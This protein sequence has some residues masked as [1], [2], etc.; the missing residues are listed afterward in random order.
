M[1]EGNPLVAQA[2]SQTTGV[3][4]IGIL[5]SANDLASGVKDGSWVEGGLGA[6]GVGLE[7]LSLVIDP[8][9]TLAQY[10]VSWLIE[11]VK[12]LKDCLDWLAGNPPVIQSFS[13]TWAN[14]AKE[15]QAIAGDLTNESQTGTAGW[16]GAAGEAYRGEVAEQVDA[17]AGAASL[18]DGI[19]TGVMVM[20]Q[21]VAAVRETVRDLIAALVGK[22]ITWALE[23]ACTL[24]FAT[25]LVAAQATAA[26]TSTISKVSQ[27]IRKLVKTI[28]NVGPKVRKI[29]DKLGEIIEKLSKLAK[30]LGKEGT[31]P[32]AA[33]TTPKGDVPTPK[34]HAPSTPDDVPGGA[35]VPGGHSPGSAGKDSPKTSRPDNP[36][37]TKTPPKRRY[38]KDDPVDVVSGE[39]ILS[40]VDLALPG[41]LPLVVQRTHVSSYRAGRLFGPNWASTLDQRLDLDALGVVFVGDDGVLLVYPDPPSDGSPVLPEAGARWPLTRTE[42][43]FRLAKPDEGLVTDFDAA[44]VI[45]AISDRNDNRLDFGYG[46]SGALEELRHSGGYHVSVQVT[47]GVVTELRLDD[48]VIA[49]YGHDERGRLDRV[50]NSSGKPLTFKYDLAGRLLK[51]ED[52]A[53]DWYG[54]RYDSAGRCVA[55][56]G[57]GG[58]LNGSF[59]YGESSTVFTDSLGATTTYKFT[60]ARQVVEETDPLGNTT[61]QEWDEL[62]R[63]IART[64]PLGRTT[65]F[66]YD[67]AGDLVGAT[68][69]DGTRAVAEYNAFGQPTVQVD[70]GGAVWR[71]GY[72]ERGN[73]TSSTDPAGAVTRYLR[74]GRGHLVGKTDPLGN[75]VRLEVDDAGLPIAVT[76]ALGDTHRYD[77]DQFGRVTRVTD[78]LGNVSTVSWTVEGKVLAKTY[79]DG[80]MDRWRYN[81]E[82]AQVEHVDPLGQVSRIETTHFELVAA[83]VDGNGGRTEF[84]YDTN[85]QLV[86]V[87]NPAGQVWRYLYDEAGNVVG[88]RDFTGRSVSYRYDAAG[89]LVGQTNGAGQQLRYVRDA[90][91]RVVARHSDDAVATF[92]FDEAGSLIRAVNA[93]AEVTLRRDVAGRITAE[94]VNGRTMAYSYDAAGNVIGRRTPSGMENGWRFDAAGRPAELRSGGRTVSFGYDPLGR[95]VER[96]L[97]TGAIMA[98]TW[99]GNHRLRTQT[100]STVAGRS[101]A[102]QAAVVQ[103]REYQYREDN[104]VTAVDDLL[105]GPKQFTLD[106]LG[107]VL[108]TSGERYGF[109]RGGNLSAAPGVHE[110]YDAQ[111]RV[112]VKQRRRLSRK[113]DTWH[114]SWDAEDRLIGVT[115]PDGTRWRYRYDPLGRRIAK[116]RLAADGSVAETVGFTW[117]GVTLAEQFGSDGRVVTWDSIG[118]SRPLTQIEHGQSEVDSRFYAIVTDLVGTP[119]ELLDPDGGL[120]W[121]AESTVWGAALGRLRNRADT[122]LRFPGQYHDDETGLNYNFFR[123]YD[124]ETGRYQSSDPLGLRAGPNP[125]AYAGNPLRTIDPLGLM[126]CDEAEK[127]LRD[128]DPDDPANAQARSEAWNRIYDDAENNPAAQ[129]AALQ[130]ERERLVRQ[131]GGQIRRGEG[132]VPNDLAGGRLDAPQ[133]HVPGSQYHVQGPGQGTPGLNMDGTFHDGDPRWPRGTYQWLYERGFAWPVEGP[134]AGRGPGGGRW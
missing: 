26:I 73:L 75:T 57:A 86:A 121:R 106:P 9:G 10:G 56:E 113:P 123:Y 40:Q 125:Y 115:T 97:D 21:V 23:E 59:E 22:L 120:A 111:G 87:K 100:I 8:I 35:D 54:Y 44:G 42:T 49:R 38:C 47:G 78:A 64:D 20:G 122:P 94:T 7:A 79:P 131:A 96:L 102:R 109:D 132:G 25:P 18:C 117:D 112:V 124:P 16:V 13:D 83:S 66:E 77:R 53:G 99:D 55:N 45:R 85:M 32:S 52:R 30:R 129:A 37:D 92:E 105:A 4:G 43:G 107:R 62:D 19:S 24:G 27:V 110:Q 108:E 36:Q 58:F 61:Y 101:P 103:Q 2:Q 1:P 76:N 31:S 14:V 68:Q 128:L 81:G 28:S 93:D 80:T 39:V 82:G 50:V 84:E 69:P 60:E 126:T 133:A 88:E 74:D 127:A 17:V 5:E 6:V 48:V 71:L 91:G 12:P 134:M 90:M 15:V 70:P 46:P 29:V 116:E 72:D 41:S 3:T 63:L 130:A 95:E 67:E 51:W 118:R 114:Y 34:E 89:Q 11:H 119:T 65:R 33:R 104:F 98:N